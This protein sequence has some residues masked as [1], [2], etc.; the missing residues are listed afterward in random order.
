MTG[1]S[2]SYQRQ[3][4]NKLAIVDVVEVLLY[5]NLI[6]LMG[7]VPYTEAL[8]GF[9][10]KTPAY[11]DAA[12]VWSDLLVRLGSDIA[13]LNAG[14][15][16][17][18]W[19]AEDLVYG[20]DVMMW[21]KFAATLK[22]RMGMRLADVNPS[23]AQS[24]LASALTAGVFEAGETFA[25]PWIGVSPHVNTINNMFIVGNRNDYAPSKTIVDLM[26][27]L[28]DPRLPEFFG[29]TDTSTEAGVEKLAYVGLEYGN[30][31]AANYYKISHF[32]DKMF[33]ADYPATIC[34]YDEVAFILA[35]A[36]QRGFTVPMSAQEYYE[37]G[38][39]E[40]VAFWEADDTELAAYM[41]QADVAYDA[42]RWKELI[43]TQKWLALYNRGN[44]GYAS[45]RTF[46]WP[47]LSPPED[48]TYGDIPMRYPYPFNEPDL[49]FE[50][51]TAASSA[52]GGDKVSTLLFWD[53]T[54]STAA[55]SPN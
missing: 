19:G 43:G 5:H 9:D 16:D 33:A 42:A 11:D 6:D 8:G 18:S 30:V 35:E 41:A 44:E 20:G 52:I 39:A 55:P 24:E 2:E 3:V 47:V 27:A 4:A 36:A 38:I 1:G 17:G 45:F 50:S 53:A 7:D 37:A 12:T 40:S 23:A 48:L 15:N 49:N 34:G 32:S 14:L 22:L 26:L 25:L 28:D 29:M 31:A 13:T 46:D 54:A 51:Y 21:K 10:N